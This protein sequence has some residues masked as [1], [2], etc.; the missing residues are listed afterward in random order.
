M[1]S[2]LG[3]K[4]IMAENIK[5][6]MK[7]H[8]LNIRQLSDKIETPYTTV[9]DWV[10]GKTYPRIDKIEQMA[11]LWQIEKSD[12]V[13]P[14]KPISN[15]ASGPL[16]MY[17]IGIFDPISCGRGLL[18]DEYATGHLAVP[19]EMIHSGN[20]YFANAAEGDSMEPKI[21]HGDYVIFEQTP[22]IQ[23]GQIGAFCLNGEYYCKRF[24]KLGDGSCW[25]ASENPTYEP[26]RI[27][28]G[29]DF[30]VLGKYKMRLTTD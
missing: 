18:V 26:I 5:R 7:L 22:E 29:D 11:N 17:T 19:V 25:L 27:H 14:Y 21:H 20:S 24:R 23:S 10:K 15:L 2:A 16:S 4:E 1:K 3:N 13:E 30:R 6:Y 9:A 8:G 12:L 28:P